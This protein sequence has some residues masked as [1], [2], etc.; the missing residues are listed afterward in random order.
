[1]LLVDHPMTFSSLLFAVL[2]CDMRD[3]PAEGIDGV[4]HREFLIG[5]RR[6]ADWAKELSRP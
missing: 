6:L 3:V 2:R 4:K 1:M 5:R